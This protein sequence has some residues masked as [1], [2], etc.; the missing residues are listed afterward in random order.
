MQSAVAQLAV[1]E[2]GLLGALAGEAADAGELLALAL[3]V[4]ELA[5]ERLRAL[6]MRCSQASRCCC[7][8]RC[9]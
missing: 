3:V 9:R 5:L 2:R 8:K 1:V 7:T 4:L 6:A